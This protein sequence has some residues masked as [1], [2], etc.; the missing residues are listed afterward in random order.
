MAQLPSIPGWNKIHHNSG[1]NNQLYQKNPGA[2]KAA[3]RPMV[4][5]RLTVAAELP[6]LSIC[7]ALV[8]CS[9]AVDEDRGAA[10]N[11]PAEAARPSG[12]DAGRSPGL[13]PGHGVRFVDVTV[14][15]HRYQVIP[16]TTSNPF[17]FDGS[18]GA[19][20][21]VSGLPRGVSSGG[22]TAGRPFLRPP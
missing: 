20:E 10:E 14:A 5:S 2:E 3:G 15:S 8:A 1:R 21:A 11:P 9:P 17:C 6:L 16:L 18:A 12:S 19:R 7:L 4:T 22:G 13:S